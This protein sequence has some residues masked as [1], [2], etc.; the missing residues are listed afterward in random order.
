VP[1]A[2]LAEL[3]F[4]WA[5]YLGLLLLAGSPLVPLLAARGL[6]RRDTPGRAARLVRTIVVTKGTLGGLGG[7]LIVCWLGGHPLLRD[8]LGQISAVWV[9]GLVA[10]V[11]AGKWLTEV[12]VTTCCCRC[13]TRAGSRKRLEGGA[14]EFS[15]P[16]SPDV[17]RLPLHRTPRGR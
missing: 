7:A 2:V 11:L 12:V 15:R 17:G 1:L 14:Q 4:R 16:T 5:P 13:C 9:V 3:A 6:L 10:R 8:L